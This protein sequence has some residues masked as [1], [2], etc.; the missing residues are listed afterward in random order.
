MVLAI[1]NRFTLKSLVQIVLVAL[2]LTLCLVA[3]AH[4][5]A[6]AF[7]QVFPTPDPANAID[8]VDATN[9][10]VY[11]LNAMGLIPVIVAFIGLVIAGVL[12]R[13]VRPRG[14]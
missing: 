6:H 5:G 7:A 2:A 8:A 10:G 3:F 14:R 13:L 9:G 1:R 4:P 12:W 11:A